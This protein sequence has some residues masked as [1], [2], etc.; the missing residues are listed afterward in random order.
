MNSCRAE[1]SNEPPSS[2]M[3]SIRRMTR[4]H[5]FLTFCVPRSFYK[6]GSPVVSRRSVLIQKRHCMNWI[7][8]SLAAL[9]AGQSPSRRSMKE[10]PK[11]VVKYS[12]VPRKG[13]TFTATKIPRGL[14]KE[15]STKSGTWGVICVTQG[16]LRYQINNN[17]EE[18][19]V[20]ILDTETRGIIEPQ[21]K[22]EVA[23]LAEDVE[24]V[25]EFYRLPDTGPVD[26]KREE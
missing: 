14:L 9:L 17:N 12:Q 24:F 2:S 25:V 18:K 16:Q 5:D 23:A 21:V 22:H 11:E 8:T 10:L 13:S 15:H 3:D 19:Q 20:Y 7:S 4:S 6:E 26:E 1:I